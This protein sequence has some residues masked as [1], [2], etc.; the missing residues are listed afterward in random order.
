M[1]ALHAVQGLQPVEQDLWHAWYHH[2]LHRHFWTSF[3][4]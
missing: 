1:H 4:Q 3:S 2:P